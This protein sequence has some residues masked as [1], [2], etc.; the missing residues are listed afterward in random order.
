MLSQTAQLGG[1]SGASSAGQQRMHLEAGDGGWQGGN[2]AR[3]P[4]NNNQ[5]VAA[6]RFF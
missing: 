4:D 6:S 1:A 2:Q 3:Q 5:L